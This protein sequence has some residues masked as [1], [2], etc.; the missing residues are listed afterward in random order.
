M[1]LPLEILLVFFENI[2]RAR[3]L[4]LHPFQNLLNSLN[5]FISKSQ[6]LAFHY[7]FSKG[8]S[9]LGCCSLSPRS[10]ANLIYNFIKFCWQSAWPPQT[11]ER[12]EFYIE[13]FFLN[14]HQRVVFHLK[15]K[16]KQAKISKNVFDSLVFFSKI[17]KQ[18]S[19]CPM[20]FCSNYA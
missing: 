3:L 18:S 4:L 9:F 16:S 13:F 10:L 1:K 14:S 11:Q 2:T 6:I 7:K 19:L 20:M 5:V 17:F 8:I 12:L 15:S